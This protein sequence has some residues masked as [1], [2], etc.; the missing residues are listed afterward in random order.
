MWFRCCVM[1]NGITFGCY[2]CHDGIFRRSDTGFIHQ[3]IRAM[4][5]IS[6]KRKTAIVDDVYAKRTQREDM[7]IQ[8]SSSDHVT[9]WGWQLEFSNARYHG[10]R[11]QNGSTNL[12]TK[13]WVQIC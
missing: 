11:N 3:K 5:T 1:N 6:S 9:P 2:R 7:C 12:A 4:Q 13:I 10:T 8:P